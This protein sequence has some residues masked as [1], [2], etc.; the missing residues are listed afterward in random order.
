M[1]SFQKFHNLS[2][3]LVNSVRSIIVP[4]VEAPITEEVTHLKIH[5]KIGGKTGYVKDDKGATMVFTSP[6][7]ANAHIDTLKKHLGPLATHAEFTHVPAIGKKSL[8]RKARLGESDE[9][10]KQQFDFEKW[11]KSGTHKK[12]VPQ[13]IKLSDGSKMLTGRT[14]LRKIKEEFIHEGKIDHFTVAKYLFTK[15]LGS[16]KGGVPNLSQVREWGQPLKIEG[17]DWSQ[18][19]QHMQHIHKQLAGGVSK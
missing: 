14:S 16:V 12:I 1:N 15:N 13:Y 7:K 18:V 3:K 6:E 10:F 8:D 5:A 11:K 17:I 19:H 2:D 9:K 4:K